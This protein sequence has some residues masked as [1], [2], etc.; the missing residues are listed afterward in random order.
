MQAPFRS[1]SPVGGERGAPRAATRLPSRVA[2]CPAGRDPS[3]PPCSCE[4]ARI[5]RLRETGLKVPERASSAG[6]SAREGSGDV[7]HRGGP[8]GDEREP[9]RRAEPSPWRELGGYKARALRSGESRGGDSGGG[10]GGLGFGRGDA[11]NPGCF[12]LVPSPGPPPLPALT[13][14]FLLSKSLPKMKCGLCPAVACCR[15]SGSS[16]QGAKA[17]RPLLSR[18]APGPRTAPRR[19]SALQPRQSSPTPGG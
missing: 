15:G 5:K 7:G 12:F 14:P 2:G 4:G 10:S 1:A 19:G 8:D 6:D 17:A 13:S 3:P 18:T 9:R 11:T 16:S